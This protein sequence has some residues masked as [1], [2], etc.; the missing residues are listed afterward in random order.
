[1]LWLCLL[2]ILPTNE[3]RY[4]RNLLASA[5]CQRCGLADETILHCLRDCAQARG[6]W[7]GVGFREDAQ[8][9]DNN[10]VSWA[11]GFLKNGNGILFACTARHVW[12]A[13]NKLIISGKI[14]S[15]FETISAI[16]SDASGLLQQLNTSISRVSLK[17]ISAP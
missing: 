8:F 5:M 13:C 12:C 6:I 3:L 14:M 15:N 9:L 4:H 1:M 2:G 17:K 11:S 10:V 7:R 16:H